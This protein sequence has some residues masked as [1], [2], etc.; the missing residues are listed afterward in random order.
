VGGKKKVIEMG[1]EERAARNP[2]KNGY[3]MY[4]HEWGKRKAK[5][6]TKLATERINFWRGST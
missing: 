1:S 6:G 3:H 5:E 4:D 2:K